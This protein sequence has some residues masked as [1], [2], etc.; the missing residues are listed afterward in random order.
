MGSDG[1]SVLAYD[2]AFFE[3][4][5]RIEDRHFWFSAR[6]R[7]ISAMVDRLTRS[8]SQGYHVLEVGCGTGNVLRVLE[9]TCASGHVVGMDLF[10]EGLLFARQRTQCSLLQADI[11]RAPFAAH[12]DIIGCFDVLEHLPDDVSV[13]HQLRSLLAPNG[14]LLLTVPAHMKLW[15]YFDEASH[16]Q[17]RYS[18]SE[19][20]GKLSD[21]GFHVEYVTP[22]MASLLPFVWLGRRLS[23]FRRR[24]RGAGFEAA[25]Q[26]ARS[27][28]RIVPVV[29]EVL[30]SILAVEARAISRQK[31]L[32]FGTSLLAVARNAGVS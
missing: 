4:L 19:M 14:A 8:Q 6:N 11:T 29:N 27:E 23:T 9:R 12:F 15:S 13:L 5:F 31:R 2:P 25:S 1:A 21:A 17:R 16:H 7:V 28:L 20:S 3:H 26:L 30:A 24:D 32:P 18:M 22:F 10:G